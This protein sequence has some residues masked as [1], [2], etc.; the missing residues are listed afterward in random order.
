MWIMREPKSSTEPP[1]RYIEMHY[2]RVR[3]HSSLGYQS[4]EQ[5]EQEYYTKLASS[6][7]R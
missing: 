1:E 6:V 7:C 2:N 4:P 5:F 3:R